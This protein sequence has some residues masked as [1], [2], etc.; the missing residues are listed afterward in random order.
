M[1]TATRRFQNSFAFVAARLRVPR[2]PLQTAQSCPRRRAGVAHDESPADAVGNSSQPLRTT[3]NRPQMVRKNLF[4]SSAEF[5]GEFVAPGGFCNTG[6]RGRSAIPKA[7]IAAGFSRSD[8]PARSVAVRH[9][10]EACPIYQIR[11]PSDTPQ[12]VGASTTFPSKWSQGRAAHLAA[13]R[14]APLTPSR[15]KYAGPWLLTRH[16]SGYSHGRPSC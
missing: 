2:P 15:G 11:G 9:A 6:C 4:A 3:A 12:L 14:S 8:S 16:L 10:T 1:R 5:V 13:R 7:T